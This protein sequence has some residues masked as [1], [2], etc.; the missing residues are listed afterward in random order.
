MMIPHSTMK[1]KAL[2]PEPH[3]KR[4]YFDIGVMLTAAGSY[5]WLWDT[6]LRW[7]TSE[8]QLRAMD[9]LITYRPFHNG[10]LFFI[11]ILQAPVMPR[12][13][14]IGCAISLGSETFHLRRD[15]LCQGVNVWKKNPMTQG[16]LPTGHKEF[17]HRFQLDQGHGNSMK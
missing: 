1:H 15:M 9:P 12:H 2:M 4:S 3:S 8:S 6:G 14:W 10:I 17:P 7:L 5:V 13:S 16:T 11:E